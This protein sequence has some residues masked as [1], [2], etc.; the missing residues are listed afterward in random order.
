MIK[1]YLK[2]GKTYYQVR[3]FARSS[4]NPNLRI[5]KQV[6]EIENL[7]IAEKEQIRLKKEYDRELSVLESRGILFGDLLDEWHEHCVKVKVSSGQR[8]LITQTDYYATIQKWFGSYAKKPA[9]DLNALAIINVFEQM[10]SEGITFGHRKKFKHVLK[11]IFDFGLQTNLIRNLFRSPTHEVVLGREVEKKP[12]ILS[13]TEIQRLLELAYGQDHEWKRVWSVALLTGMRSGEI[14]ALHKNDVDFENK[15]I[16]VNKSHNCRLKTYKST[17]A[18]YWRQVPISEDLEKILKEQF[19]VNADSDYVFEKFTGWEKGDQARILRSF[20]YINGLP[21][22]RF[23][24]LRACFAT[25]MLRS[26]V[27]PAK[28]MK[29]CGWKELK[30]MQRYVRLAGIDVM[31]ATEVIKIMPKSQR[32]NEGS[33]IELKSLG[34]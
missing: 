6:G 30:T 31:G 9:S 8:T 5:T 10:K 21:S 2:N 11:S 18:G 3:I 15:L 14:L 13:L 25:Q 22:I 24:T 12:E 23:H 34:S 20:C 16:N 19:L 32:T 4:I 17:K 29:I 33:V 1:Q 26:G 7:A 28:V 27:E